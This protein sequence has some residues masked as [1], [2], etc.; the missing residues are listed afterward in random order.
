MD[1]PIQLTFRPANISDARSIW[2]MRNDPVS[3]EASINTEFIEYENH[4][5]WFQQSL[6]NPDRKIFIVEREG[7][8]V[9][10]VRADAIRDGHKITWIVAP[11]ERGRGI[12][13]KMVKAFIEQFHETVYAEVKKNNFFSIRVA[14]NCGM[15]KYDEVDGVLYYRK[16]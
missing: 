2:E 3:R 10:L 1:K 4:V 14:E 16:N 11:A 8:P 13:K 9:G 5:K 6:E 12:G 15:R 7:S